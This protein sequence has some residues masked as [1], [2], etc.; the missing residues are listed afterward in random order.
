MF[1]SR[2]WAAKDFNP[3]AVKS[4]IRSKIGRGK[5]SI[6]GFKS[7]YSIINATPAGA[8]YETAG[9]KN[10]NGDPKSKSR[11]PNAGKQFIDAIQ[12]QSGQREPR[13]KHEGRIAFAAVEKNNG[14]AVKAIYEAV[15]ESQKLY[16][17][18]ADA[19]SGFG[20]E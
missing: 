10:P 13:G 8:I 18:R 14:K 2:A 5:K 17:I 7:V 15:L 4:G 12:K 3:N 11:N 16:K 1:N 9:R 6:N 19:R 20:G